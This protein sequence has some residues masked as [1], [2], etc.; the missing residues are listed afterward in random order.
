MG[1]WFVNF[2]AGGLWVLVFNMLGWLHLS[3]QPHT[4]ADPTFG[5]LLDA[6]V[7]AVVIALMG[8]VAAF[9]WA[10]FV[11]ATLGLGCLFLP[12]YW[13]LVGYIKLS[14]ASMLLPG[15]FDYSHNLLFVVIMSWILGASRW[16]HTREYR[17]HQVEAADA[18]EVKAEWRELP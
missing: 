1:R 7:I 13:L 14:L 10:V 18:R 5:H 17:R 15:W 16:H 12:L 6:A 4:L 11:I 2:L 3:A 9:L 8:E